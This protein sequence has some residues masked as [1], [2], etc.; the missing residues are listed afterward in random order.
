MCFEYNENGD[1]ISE[2]Q[3]EDNENDYSSEKIRENNLHSSN[4][5]EEEKEEKENTTRNYTHKHGSNKDFKWISPETQLHYRERTRKL[6]YHAYESY[7][8]Y[9][10]PAGELKPL[11]C[12]GGNFDLIKIP[13][14]TLFD[15]LDTLVILGN[16]S[17]FIHV[18][19]IIETQMPT[20]DI[21]ENVSLFETNIRILGG[22]LSAHLM[23][24][25]PRLGIYQSHDLVYNNI[26]LDLA[27]DLGNRLLPAFKTA[28]GIPYGTVNLRHGVPPRESELASLAGAGTLLIE[29]EILSTLTGNP[30]Y[31]KEALKATL[32]L[33]EYRSSLGL[34][35]KHINVQTGKWHES[36]SGIGSNA[37]SYYEY[38]FK[39]YLLFHS[40]LLF[41][42]FSDLFIAIKKYVQIGNW[43]SETDIFNLR[44][45]RHR[46]ESLQAFWPGL[47]V[48]IKIMKYY[49]SQ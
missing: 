11:S 31:G 37:E 44:Y 47:E 41:N 7:M 16:Y 10:F 2:N 12:T 28:T 14:V 13:L 22:L 3:D 39:S 48:K 26:L 25:D 17:E 33:Y 4:E 8:K 9:A 46:F 15:T 49:K 6:F 45:R 27:I 36:S 1:M 42:K 40:E 30:I 23:A 32:A 38:L 21:D 35:G 43:F 29:F 19:N 34:M 5:D 24:A 18:V 20:F